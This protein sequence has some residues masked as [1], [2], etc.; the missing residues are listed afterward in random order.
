MSRGVEKFPL[1]AGKDWG[2]I[3]DNAKTLRGAEKGKRE[4]A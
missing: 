4:K 2:R 1:A 3:K